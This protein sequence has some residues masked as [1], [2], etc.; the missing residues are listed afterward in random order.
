MKR[1]FWR[2]RSEE[3]FSTGVRVLLAGYRILGRRAGD[4]I[5]WWVIAAYWLFNRRARRISRDYLDRVE[6]FAERS[7]KGRLRLSTLAHFERFGH[8]IAERILAWSGVM[9]RSEADYR[10]GAFE[11][12]AELS[13]EG[14]SV[15]LL[16]SHLGNTEILRAFNTRKLRVAVN[17]LMDSRNSRKMAE[18]IR[19]TNAEAAVHVVEADDEDSVMSAFLGDAM[20]KGEWFAMMADR[21]T[22]ETSRR[23][24]RAELLGE[25]VILPASP[26]IVAS[27]FRLP[28]FLIHAVRDG[29]SYSVYLKEIGPVALDRRNRSA[30]AARYAEMYCRELERLILEAPYD[31]F[32]FYDFWREDAGS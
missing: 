6:R 5:T 4:F 12:L 22:K 20:E 15:L 11:R 17:V 30:S 32:N 10:D 19:R 27:A 29:K 14:K 7:G 13:R 1:L 24:V 21:L 23:T 2:D 8:A 26:W 31:W 25:E 28:V 9:T 3:T 18:I 16:S